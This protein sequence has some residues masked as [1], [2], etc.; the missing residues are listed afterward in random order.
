MSLR[1]FN[2]LAA[3]VLFAAAPAAA[4]EFRF[5]SGVDYSSGD[6]GE[7][8]DTTIVT[9]PLSAAY[10]GERWSVSVTV[11]FASVEGPG[12]VV[13]GSGGSGLGGFGPT[14]SLTD[15]LLFGPDAADDPTP[16]ANI[17]EQGLADVTVAAGVT[18]IETEG[19]LRLTLNGAVRAPTGDA[20]R[21]LGTGET[22]G[23]LSTT[24]AQRFGRSAIYGV[25]GAERAFES[26]QDGVFAGVGAEGYV[27][28][29]GLLGASLNWSEA[30]SDSLRDAAQASAYAGYDLTPSLQ[31]RGYAAAGLT[32]TSP[33]MAAGVRLVFSAARD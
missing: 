27:T 6:Y 16:G 5:G 26:E 22:S 21:S 11:P 1:S 17:S 20:E 23:S 33:D 4:Q 10:V 9:V 24:L 28:D 19:G 7:A 31:V 12:T 3:L 8:E 2:T 13:P 29:K 30:T 25:V 32:D 15:A 18:P 14:S